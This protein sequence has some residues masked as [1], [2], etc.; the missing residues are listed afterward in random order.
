M[1]KVRRLPERVRGRV[2]NIG[3]RERRH[4]GKEVNT[5]ASS[6]GGSME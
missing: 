3:V 6:G 1:R 2:G 4:S 5:P